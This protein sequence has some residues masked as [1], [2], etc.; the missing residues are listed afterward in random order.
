MTL[1]EQ[2]LLDVEN[3]FL[4]DMTHT[5]I[6]KSNQIKVQFFKESLDKMDT[7]YDLCWVAYTDVPNIAINDLLEI[8]NINYGVVDFTI[9]E[10]KHGVN[11]FLSKV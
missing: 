7:Q 3:I 5:A 9:D 6:Y 2:M 8:D 11:L 1:D 10:F 4:S